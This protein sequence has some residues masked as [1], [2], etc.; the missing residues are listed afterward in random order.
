MQYYMMSI[1]ISIRFILFLIQFIKKKKGERKHPLSELLMTE[2]Q[3]MVKCDV[4]VWSFFEKKNKIKKG[5]KPKN[6]P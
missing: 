2:A 3:L 5:K 1:S 4:T 6:K